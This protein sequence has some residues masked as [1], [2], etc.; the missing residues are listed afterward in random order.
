M[1]SPTSAG[2]GLPANWWLK[3]NAKPVHSMSDF[4]K[5]VKGELRHKHVFID[6]YMEHCPYCYY[7]L[8]D[9]N[10][11]IDELTEM[12]G[13]EEVAFL[14]VNGQVVTSI[15]SKYKVHS[16]PKF[17]A[18]KPNSEGNRYE[19]F[20]GATR[21]YENLRKWMLDLMGNTPLLGEPRCDHEHDEEL[22]SGSNSQATSY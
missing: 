1:A 4:N 17:I 14:K 8:D 10:Q 7:C 5:L 15:S 16:Y 22:A 20:G 21:T 11:L 6:F 3:A 2:G 9:F 19:V 18:L 12:Y 13:P